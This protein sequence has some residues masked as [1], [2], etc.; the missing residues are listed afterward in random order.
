[1]RIFSKKGMTLV[2]LIVSSAVIV[3]VMAAAMGALKVSLDSF[4][5]GTMN[6]KSHEGINLA[7]QYITASFKDAV[8]CE[9]F[10]Y[11]DT[12]QVLLKPGISF[13]IENQDEQD[14]LFVCRDGKNIA[15][16]TNVG[17]LSVKTVEVGEGN[18]K[19]INLQ[20]ALVSE[21]SEKTEHKTMTLSGSGT[22][23]NCTDFG[24][25]G[26]DKEI[27]SGSMLCLNIANAGSAAS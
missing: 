11:A 18:S 27:T 19:R 3:I 13:Y 14:I 16:I 2:E 5:S 25:S 20:Y 21:D 15:R 26:I 23:L 8:S 10:T 6:A 7:E 22:L 12:S 24:I 4:K 9:V 17:K 1:M